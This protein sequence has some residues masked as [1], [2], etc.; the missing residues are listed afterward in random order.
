MPIYIIFDSKI[1]L[2]IIVGTV[3]A[4]LAQRDNRNTEVR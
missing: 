4:A 3:P 2:H 1:K